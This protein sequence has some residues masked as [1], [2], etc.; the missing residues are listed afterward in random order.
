MK[1][2]ASV[3]TIRIPNELKHRIEKI[4][5]QQG[6]SINQLALYAFTKEIQEMETFKSFS[7]YWKNKSKKELFNDFDSVMLK[8]GNGP[9]PDWDKLK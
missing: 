3:L 6:I 2:K 8:A 5:D 1:A 7:K 4:A 9:V